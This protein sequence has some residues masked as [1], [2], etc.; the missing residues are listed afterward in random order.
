VN[1][2]LAQLM[3]YLNSQRDAWQQT[4]RGQGNTDTSW[5]DWMQT[6]NGGANRRGVQDWITQNWGAAPKFDPTNPG[7]DPTAMNNYLLWQKGRNALNS[8]WDTWLKQ[9]SVNYTNP[10][11]LPMG[12]RMQLPVTDW[13]RLAGPDM[14]IQ[15]G[16]AERAQPS[17][18]AA[19]YRGGSFGPTGRTPSWTQAGK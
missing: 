14:G 8:A 13:T 10:I 11:R 1:A 9:N 17:P 5:Y 7:D 12:N 19:N 6:A 16:F 3:A 15:S 4:Y 18:W 2:Y